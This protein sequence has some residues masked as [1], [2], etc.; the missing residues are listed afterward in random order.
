MNILSFLS[1]T[2]FILFVLLGFYC[3]K[4]NKHQTLNQFAFYECIV[5]SI[6]A[7]A[8]TFFYTAASPDEAM[9][10]HRIGCIGGS[11]FPPFS[12]YFFLI[13]SRREH[14]LSR[15]WLQ[16]LFYG[17]PIVILIKNLIGNTTCLAT[18]FVQS[19]SGLGWTYLNSITN[20]WTWIYVLYLCV[21]F[22]IGFYLM[23]EWR[24]ESAYQVQKRQVMAIIIIDLIVLSFGVTTD[25]VLPLIT[26]F[27]P[28][29]ANL[30]TF[31]FAVGFFTLSVN[32][33]CSHFPPWLLQILF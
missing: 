16:L 7:F 15:R 25:I 9:F 10:W 6:W 4:L 2:I 23:L 17:I 12:V 13:L 26:P 33:S 29:M 21:Y 18:G 30:G 31:L 11:L 8:Y 24:K 14:V 28:P 3:L 1:F 22:W 5:L 20:V 19:T 32:I 27:L